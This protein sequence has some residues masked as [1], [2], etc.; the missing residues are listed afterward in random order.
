MT[1]ACPKCNTSQSLDSVSSE[2]DS[3]ICKKCGSSFSFE[4]KTQIVD[5]NVPPHVIEDLEET[6]TDVTREANVIGKI[7]G[8][9]RIKK[10]LGQGAM[11]VVYK[12]HH[13]ALD[14]PVAL[15]I[16]PIHIAQRKLATERFIR[17]ARTAARL[18]HPNIVGVLNVGEEDGQHYIIMDFVDGQSLQDLLKEKG[19]LSNVEAVEIIQQIGNALALA[20]KNKIVHRDIKPDNILIDREG[21]AKLADLGLAKFT[22][23]DASMTQSGITMG[24]PYF[25]APEQSKD[26]K[27]C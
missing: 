11:G 1:A 8:G 16:L 2:K 7:I 15:K 20:H 12:T 4:T 24:T 10:I 26:S 21:V 3:V 18:K 27:K 5:E 23:E 19:V 6:V 9:C 25:I 13:I 17:E 22:E 14:I